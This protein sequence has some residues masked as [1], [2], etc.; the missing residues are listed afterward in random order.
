[1]LAMLNLSL[2]HTHTHTTHKPLAHLSFSVSHLTVAQAS[3]ISK[4][5][6]KRTSAHTYTHSRRENREN[7]RE[8]IQY[9]NWWWHVKQC[10]CMCIHA[11]CSNS[12]Y[13]PGARRQL[14]VAWIT[15]LWLGHCPSD[16][17]PLHKQASLFLLLLPSHFGL[18]CIHPP[19]LMFVFFNVC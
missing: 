8:K 4:C 2:S 17:T 9:A 19:S 6:I 3:L 15:A 18:F 10:V 11:C 5:A 1:M 13:G 12:A 14:G 16:T 7:K